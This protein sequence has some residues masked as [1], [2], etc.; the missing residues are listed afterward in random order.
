M[1]ALFLAGLLLWAGTALLFVAPSVPWQLEEHPGLLRLQPGLSLWQRGGLGL[2]L[3]GL[4]GFLLLAW[5]GKVEI[6]LLANGLALLAAVV[7]LVWLLQRAPRRV[8]FNRQRDLVAQGARRVGRLSDLVAVETASDPSRWGLVFRSAG[9]QEMRWT[10][11][12]ASLA[13]HPTLATELGAAL[14]I[15]VRAAPPPR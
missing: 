5:T 15:P 4:A 12:P 9:S 14:G 2:V 1:L 11:P 13:A 3:A 6:P 8:I 7:N 10:L